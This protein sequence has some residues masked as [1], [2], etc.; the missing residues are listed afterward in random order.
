MWK[1]V[2]DAIAFADNDEKAGHSCLYED[3]QQ[4]VEHERKLAAVEREYRGYRVAAI[5][6]GDTGLRVI[7][8]LQRTINVPSKQDG[9]SI[10]DT[11]A[12]NMDK[13]SL[14]RCHADYHMLI[15]KPGSADTKNED[16]K[17]SLDYLEICFIIAGLGVDEG[18]WLAPA[19]TR[20]SWDQ[21][22]S[23]VR[24]A[25]VSRPLLDECSSPEHVDE[26]I[27]KLMEA[28][29][30]TIVL[31]HDIVNKLKPGLSK[32]YE[33]SVM[34]Q[35]KVETVDMFLDFCVRIGYL[36]IK[37]SDLMTIVRNSGI[38]VLYYGEYKST[39]DMLEATKEQVA[40][41]MLDV[42]ENG[43]QGIM[44]VINGRQDMRLKDAEIIIETFMDGIEPQTQNFV[45]NCRVTDG[46]VR[47]M[48]LATGIKE[49][50]GLRP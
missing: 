40:R 4:M 15:E 10:M 33:L 29:D 35:L 44:A 47:L 25:I 12:V 9:R 23:D 43:R 39:A 20:L 11:M 6:C 16:M 28:A 31:D 41:P 26:S 17:R 1:L 50:K 22:F 48:A 42:K 34:D 18:D 2:E 36:N 49:F 7:D 32:K 3:Y 5:G 13:E 30:V 14:L 21:C 27:R 38:G 45:W 8:R 19:I 46:R 37:L 24:I